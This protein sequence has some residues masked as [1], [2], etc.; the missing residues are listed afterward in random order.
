MMKDGKPFQDGLYA[1]NRHAAMPV[2]LHFDTEL[3]PFGT[4]IN[5][6]TPAREAR[7]KPGHGAGTEGPHA[8]SP[9]N[10]ADPAD[11]PLYPVR[12]GVTPSTAALPS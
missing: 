11:E 4:M 10:Q 6:P 5:P 2:G 9:A 3:A 12:L 1:A 8:L 7:R